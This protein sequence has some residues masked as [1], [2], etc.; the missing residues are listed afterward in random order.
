MRLL[1]LRN[2]ALALAIIVICMPESAI[3]A[4][5]ASPA[6]RAHRKPVDRAVDSALAFLA[7]SQTANPAKDGSFS[8]WNGGTNGVVGLVGMSFLAHGYRPGAPPYG[9]T[10]NSTIDY[11]LST[12]ADNGYLGVRGGKMYSHGIA[13]L[14][15]SEVSGMVDPRRQKRI[16]KVLP[17]ALKV[18]LD[19]QSRNQKGAWRYE[20]TSIDADVSVTG[21]NLMALRS[22]RLNG[23]PVPKAAI[24]RAIGFIDSCRSRNLRLVDGARASDDGGYW[25]HAP[26]YYSRRNYWIGGPSTPARTGGALLCREL[27]GRHDDATNR[28][29]GDFILRHVK[30]HGF[31][32]DGFHAYATYYCSQG[33]FQLGGHYWE[34]FGEAMYKHL[35]AKQQDNGAWFFKGR[36]EVYPT[37]MYTLALSVGYRQLPIYQR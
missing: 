31:I 27:S 1:D 13:T 23:A 34:K 17:R 12:S 3:H 37:A 24:D 35:L 16:D 36:G 10:I 8:D 32:K 29:A 2:L 6:L 11:I 4:D 15:L 21:W 9:E 20:P 33:M 5:E 30:A 26:Q 7:R 14:Y 19:A 25:Y 22:A 18:I 28:K